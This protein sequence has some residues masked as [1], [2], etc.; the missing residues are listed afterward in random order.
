MILRTLRKRLEPKDH[1]SGHRRN[2]Q[3]SDDIR[4]I[5]SPRGWSRGQGRGGDPSTGVKMTGGVPWRR[6]QNHHQ[7]HS[8]Q[9][10]FLPHTRYQERKTP[11]PNFRLDQFDWR[12]HE[13]TRTKQESCLSSLTIRLRRKKLI[14]STSPLQRLT[15]LATRLPNIGSATTAFSISFSFLHRTKKEDI[16]TH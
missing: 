13:Q 16:A 14:F 5:W 8:T 12:P 4:Q 11:S 10:P 2:L 1:V 15:F 3:D 7:I 9:P 6:D